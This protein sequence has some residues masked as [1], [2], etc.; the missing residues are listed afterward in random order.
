MK[1]RRELGPKKVKNRSALI[2]YMLFALIAAVIGTI[3][4]CLTY[5]MIPAPSAETPTALNNTPTSDTPAANPGDQ[6]DEGASSASKKDHNKL[7]IFNFFFV[8]FLTA[9]IITVVG[10][11]FFGVRAYMM[12]VQ[13]RHSMLSNRKRKKI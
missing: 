6:A 3:L 1:P 13:V 8:I 12:G 2:K 4:T 11:L 9:T 5:S 10:L 7:S